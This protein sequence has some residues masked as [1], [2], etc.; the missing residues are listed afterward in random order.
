MSKKP[1]LRYQEITQ[2]DTDDDFL[3]MREH[4]REEILTLRKRA[5]QKAKRNIR[6]QLEERH[7]DIDEARDKIFGAMDRNI[8]EEFEAVFG[9][10]PHNSE[11][12]VIREGWFENGCSLEGMR[13]LEGSVVQAP[14]GE[15]FPG[16]TERVTVKNGQPVYGVGK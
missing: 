14:D 7:M 9:R 16:Q 15:R 1:V 5:R 6:T 11:V 13:F 3:A 4:A 10:A 8:R 2:P 12:A